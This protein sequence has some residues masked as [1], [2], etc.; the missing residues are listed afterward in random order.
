ML[1]SVKSGGSFSRPILFS[2][3]AA[4]HRANGAMGKVLFDV[5]CARYVPHAYRSSTNSTT[6]HKNEEED[7]ST[8]GSAELDERARRFSLQQTQK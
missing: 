8:R 5:N 6:S 3:A 7:H 4:Q 2:P 1:S